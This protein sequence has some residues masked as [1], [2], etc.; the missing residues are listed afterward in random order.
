MQDTHTHTHTLHLSIDTHI[1]IVNYTEACGKTFKSPFEN[2]KSQ[3]INGKMFYS[4][5]NSATTNI[6]T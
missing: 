3:V 2:S 6:I 1:H 5:N 4:A